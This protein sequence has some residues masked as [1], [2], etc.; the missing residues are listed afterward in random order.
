MTV[1]IDVSETRSTSRYTLF[2]VSSVDDTTNAK[3]MPSF[4]VQHI[5]ITFLF[6]DDRKTTEILHRLG[7]GWECDKISSEVNMSH[8]SVVFIIREELKLRKIT[9]T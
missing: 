3:E 9:T 8:G 4:G 1:G 5:I 2:T 7:L 6:V